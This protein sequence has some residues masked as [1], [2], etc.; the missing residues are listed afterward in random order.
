M[1][2]ATESIPANPEEQIAALQTKLREVTANSSALATEFMTH[3][4]T[5]ANE[6]AYLTTK[7]EQLNEIRDGHAATIA[8]LASEQLR[9]TRQNDD[10]VHRLTEVGNLIQSMGQDRMKL[11]DK[12]GEWEDGLMVA[13]REGWRSQTPRGV[14]TPRTP[15]EAVMSSKSRKETKMF[16]FPEEDTVDDVK[17]NAEENGKDSVK[18]AA[19]EHEVEKDSLDIEKKEETE[20]ETEEAK[21]AEETEETK[22]NEEK[23]DEVLMVRSADSGEAV[24]GNIASF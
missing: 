24:L 2:T 11:M 4:E 23:E 20:D 15:R 9:I 13:G 3:R 19:V 5:L 10:I 12:V 7:I 6:N 8:H 1:S 17:E 16:E 14:Y 18:D 22:E 21:K